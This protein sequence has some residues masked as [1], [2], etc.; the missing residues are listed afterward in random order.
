MD[1][2][3][4]ETCRIYLLMRHRAVQYEGKRKSIVGKGFLVFPNAALIFLV[5]KTSVLFPQ[6]KGGSPSSQAMKST[7]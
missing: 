3:D 6:T 4:K 2:L 7:K 1:I 5:M